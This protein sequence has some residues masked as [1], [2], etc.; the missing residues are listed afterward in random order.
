MKDVGLMVLAVATM[1]P[2][3]AFAFYRGIC[4]GRA[5]QC[6]KRSKRIVPAIKHTTLWAS[7]AATLFAMT[8]SDTPGS[9]GQ[10]VFWLHSAK[11]FGESFLFFVIACGIPFSIGMLLKPQT[12]RVQRI[13][14]T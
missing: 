12:N 13:S 9:I 3:P 6:Q 2:F 4:H 14:T 10:L 7:I 1:L 11:T 8:D 5:R